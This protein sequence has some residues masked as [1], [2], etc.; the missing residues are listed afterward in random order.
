M[1]SL[2]NMQWNHTYLVKFDK[3]NEEYKIF[4]T[5]TQISNTINIQQGQIVQY[6]RTYPVNIRVPKLIHIT[7]K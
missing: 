3:Q 4:K 5:L 6:L 2:Y 7:W 1:I